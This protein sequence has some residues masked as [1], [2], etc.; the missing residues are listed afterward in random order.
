MFQKKWLYN[1][2]YVILAALI[3]FFLLTHSPDYVDYDAPSYIFFA[4]IRPPVYPIF[5]WLFRWAGH[6]QF[7]LIMWVH[8]ILTFSAF[9][10]A[11]FWLKKYLKISDFLIFIVLLL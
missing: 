6:Y 7:T 2:S 4:P 5:I 9:L 10:Y 3:V 1:L 11:G 8:A